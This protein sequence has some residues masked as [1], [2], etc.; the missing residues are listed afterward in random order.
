MDSMPSITVK[1]KEAVIKQLQLP[2][3]DLSIGR[4]LT[5]ALVLDDAAVSADHASIL[6]RRPGFLFKGSG[7]HQRHLHQ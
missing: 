6:Y 2:Q 3:G 7:Q 1:L 5:H 4:R